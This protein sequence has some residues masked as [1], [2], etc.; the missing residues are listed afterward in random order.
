M[1]KVGAGEGRR[2]GGAMRWCYEGRGA[3]PPMRTRQEVVVLLKGRAAE[4]RRGVVV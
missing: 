2:G 1:R 4:G 3:A